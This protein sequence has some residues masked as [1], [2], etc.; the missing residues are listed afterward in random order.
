[1]PISI[2]VGVTIDYFIKFGNTASFLGYFFTGSLVLLYICTGITIA[3]NRNIFKCLKALGFR[4]VFLSCA[5]LAG[6]LIGGIVSGLLRLR[7]QSLLSSCHFCC[8]FYTTYCAN[9]GLRQFFSPLC[10][11]LVSAETLT[12]DPSGCF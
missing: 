8:L 9:P 1:M 11:G 6:S 4:V 7:E 3:V 5:I 12:R 2:I 10:R